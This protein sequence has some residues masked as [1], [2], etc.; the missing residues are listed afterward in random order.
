[1]APG[2]LLRNGLAVM[3]LA[4][5]ALA[6]LPAG[7]GTYSNAATAFAPVDPATHTNVTWTN[8]AQCTTPGGWAGAAAVDDDIS[9]TIP[10]GFTFTFGV[11]GYTL[12]RIMSNGRV[13]FTNANCGNGGDAV[14]S[15]AT[16]AGFGGDIR[17]FGADLDASV[18]G[19]GTTCPAATCFVRFAS[20]GVTPNR[21]FVVT[22]TNVPRWNVAGSAH[23]VQI[24]LQENGDFILQWGAQ[25]GAAV[26]ALYGWQ[27]NT[28][29]PDSF[30][31]AGT[32]GAAGTLNNS[33][34]RFFVPVPLIEYR[35]E[36][37]SFAAGVTNTGSGGATY[38]GTV[39]GAVTSLAA[40]K[41]CRGATV[42]NNGL[43]ATDAI[44]TNADLDTVIG[45]TGT[46]TF[47]Y[48]SLLAWNSGIVDRTLFDAGT[49]SGA[50]KEFWLALLSNGRLRFELEDAADVNINAE[51]IPGGAAAGANT[52]VHIGVTWNF[53]AGRMTLYANGARVAQRTGGAISLANFNTLYLG[54]N[55]AGV[56]VGNN[57]GNS[58][59]G[60]LD[61]VRIY[62]GVEGGS[63]LVTRD[64]NITA[65]C[66]DHYQITHSGTGIN[67]QP[68]NVTI[69]AHDASHAAVVPA[70]TITVTARRVAGAAGN[71]GDWSLVAGTGILNNGAA[72]DGIATY[73]FG[74]GESSVVL[75]LKDTLVQTMN[76]DLLDGGA[77]TE[78]TGTGGSHADPDLNFVQAG[79]K[80]TS[81]IATQIA[82]TTSVSY[83][84]QAIRTDLKTGV[85][86]GVFT[87]LVPN[88][89]LA[90]E[91]VNPSTCQAGQQV[92][93]INN[94]P[95]L[96]AANPAG[97]PSSYTTRT[98]NFGASSTAQFTFDYPDVG[99]IRL[100]VR[101]NIP[102]GGGG[103]SGNLMAG[104]TD[105]GGFVVKPFG[106]TVSNIRRTSDS[107]ANP[108]AVNATGAAFLRAGQ[109]MTLTV[110]A[111]N[112]AG[113][114]TP[115][116]GRE[117]TP[118]GVLL[119]PALVAGLGLTN[120]PALGN[121]VI[122]GSEF[123]AGGAVVDANGVATVTNVSWSEAGIITIT[124][125]V[126]DGD[127]LGAGNVTGTAT[128]N[129]GR[130]FPDHFALLAVPAPTLTNR[131]ALACA[132]ASTF[133]Y[134]GE[135]ISLAFTLQAQNSSNVVTPNYRT[136][137]IAAQNFGKLDLTLPANLGFGARSGAT[138]LTPRVG[139]ATSA[140]TWTNGQA[141][142]TATVAINR[143]TPDN[144]DG[145]YAGTAFGILPTDSDAVT[146]AP[147]DQDV[148]G[149]GGNDHRSLGL[150]T[151]AR[152]GRLL[153]QNAVGSEKLALPVRIETQHFAGTGFLTNAADSC[154]T[155]GR[156]KITLDFIPPSNLVACETAVS[157]ATIAFASGVGT[158][159]LAAP[160]AG[161]NG[162]VLL[163]P[164]LGTTAGGTYCPSVGG[165]PTVTNAANMSY[166]LG[167]WNDSLNPDANANTAYDDNPAARA[168][169]GLYS[170]QPKNFIFFRENY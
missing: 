5:T 98:L 48:R 79:F 46:V 3:A 24:I 33:A 120:N 71:H 167:R 68:E 129:V 107:F 108:A 80:F 11:T 35:F 14:K 21:T 146:I 70:S 159:A 20:L 170:S 105:V 41:V 117:T 114:P 88:I 138:N 161:N 168:A 104:A 106:F 92:N 59:N 123:G 8:G 96:I 115:N 148:D 119:T 83:D 136:S 131:A 64:M 13:Q 60:D 102:L 162:S 10:I 100:Y 76:I 77:I 1:M 139:T 61:Q 111:T 112:Q 113:N 12:L 154:T 122:A 66:L 54:D 75:G 22:W 43:A 110:T 34:V 17:V 121:N 93:F 53:P 39:V 135:G 85:C 52:W 28:T 30:Q 90:L 158:L 23:T 19:T 147:L 42:P 94:G 152:F 2:G 51:W 109:A 116:Y 164:Q 49:G 58:A 145:P 160:G 143:A 133:S 142:V 50:N 156:D 73:A 137:G 140:G 29:D 9:A 155:L 97:A 57:A 128:G 37:S 18:A 84:L 62:N 63:A 82:G 44:N 7:A 31:G 40:A 151:E 32:L 150:S 127:Y 25:A 163:T 78:S 149:V 165:A 72:D 126:G 153:L 166:L 91:C 69:A 4:A 144:P 81:P 26:N 38:N 101:Y 130:F 99:A 15:I 157:Q 55:R 56:A 169:F 65:I 118:E 125:S 103:P 45:D 27:L 89:E 36:Q 124:P 86:A 134:M 141:N 67:C 74:V 6:A 87:G 95:G 132:P 47:W 16:D